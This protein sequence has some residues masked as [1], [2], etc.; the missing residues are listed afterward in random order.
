MR[1]V[2]VSPLGVRVSVPGLMMRPEHR[3]AFF[4]GGGKLQS[5]RYCLRLSKRDFPI[6]GNHDWERTDFQIMESKPRQWD[7]FGNLI[8]VLKRAEG[9]TSGCIA[10]LDMFPG[11]GG[12]GIL[13]SWNGQVSILGH[14]MCMVPSPRRGKASGRSIEIDYPV[15]VCAEGASFSWE[16]T[17]N[18]FGRP[19]GY[20]ATLSDGVLA[21]SPENQHLPARAEA[22]L[23]ERVF[24]RL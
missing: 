22:V 16:R 1:V 11:E 12:M 10:L 19:S 9:R 24:L 17:G 6:S 23:A 15:L 2:K 8:H 18:T 4:H 5:C 7:E 20:T 13:H 14:G 21:V 3:F